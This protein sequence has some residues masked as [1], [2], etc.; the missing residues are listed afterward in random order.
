MGLPVIG[1]S[2]TGLHSYCHRYPP[3]DTSLK[4]SYIDGKHKFEKKSY[5]LLGNDRY[6]FCIDLVFA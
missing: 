6:F 3:M 1:Y 4:F 5:E 2:P